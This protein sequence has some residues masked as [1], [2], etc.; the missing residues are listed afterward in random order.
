MKKKTLIALSVGAIAIIII[1]AILMIAVLQNSSLSDYELKIRE[2]EK[3]M[4]SGDYDKAIIAYKAALALDSSSEE[5]YLG[6][7]R[8]YIRTGRDSLAL[9]VLREGYENT[10]SEQLGQMLEDSGVSIDSPQESTPAEPSEDEQESAENTVMLNEALLYYFYSASYADYNTKYGNLQCTVNEN[11]CTVTVPG[12]NATITFMESEGTRVIDRGNGKPYDGMIPNKIVLSDVMELFIGANRVSYDDLTRISAISNLGRNGSKISFYACGCNVTI[13]CNG[14]GVFGSGASHTIVPT[15]T[16][17]EE[18]A[19]YELYGR[20]LDADSSEGIEGVTMVA[21]PES[22]SSNR[23]T[24]TS[25]SN[26]AYWIVLQGSGRYTIELSKRGY[27]SQRYTVEISEG[28]LEKNFTLEKKETPATEAPTTEAPTTEAPT[29]EAPTTEAPT[30][31]APTTEPP[32]VPCELKGTVV[33]ATTGNAVEGVELTI[34][35]ADGG[36]AQQ[37]V[38]TDSNGAYAVTVESGRNYTISSRKSGYISESASVSI[39][40][41]ETVKDVYLTISPEMRSGEIRIVLTWGEQPVDLDSHL[42]GT[43]S[44]GAGVHCYYS[45]KRCYNNSGDRI[46]YLDVDD[47]NGYGPETTTLTDINGEY[48]F[49]VVDFKSTGTMGQVSGATVKI[50]IGD[51]LAYTLTIPENASNRWN[52][53]RI[54]RGEIQIVNTG[55]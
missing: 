49:Y 15:G 35:A 20:V 41:E 54:V 46:A 17:S 43:A 19:V 53:C 2:A 34:I 50:Y 45:N 16:P 22:D 1:A 24:V 5:A 29:T 18:N 32:R 39:G 30:T 40:F 9:E 6:L 13:E 51:S 21:Y 47:T 4:Q 10:N 25:S 14:D 26:G 31:E 3:Y 33:D 11:T 48:D 44:D 28:S 38:T 55:E 27:D 52:V 7:Y 12:L 8:A 36:Y 23:T 37:S 42:R